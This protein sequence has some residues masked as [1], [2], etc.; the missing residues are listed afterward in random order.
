MPESSPAADRL[1][2]LINDAGIGTAVARRIYA[3]CASKTN[4]TDMPAIA[5]GV[6]TAELLI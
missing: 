3:R 1:D 4:M 5:S 2:I 6:N